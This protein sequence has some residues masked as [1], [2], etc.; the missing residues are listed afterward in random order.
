MAEA[1]L[2]PEVIEIPTD[3]SATVR[4]VVRD[5]VQA[6]GCPEAMFCFSD[7]M[8]LGVYRGLRDLGVRIPEDTALVGCDG[9]EW[10]EFVD[11]PISTIVPPAQECCALAWQYLLQRLREPDS[12]LQQTVLRSHLLVR[13]SSRR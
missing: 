9:I 8:A 1:G 4:Q 5:Y 6:N 11:Q 7:H 2:A 13:E 3:S 12:P 10:A